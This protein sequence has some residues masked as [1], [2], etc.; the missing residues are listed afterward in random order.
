MQATDAVLPSLRLQLQQQ[1][2]QL[3]ALAGEARLG[4]LVHPPWRGSL[5]Q[6]HFCR[7][8]AFLQELLN[9]HFKPKLHQ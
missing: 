3:G 7:R 9:G 8:E 4:S 2:T 1:I 6:L 5:L